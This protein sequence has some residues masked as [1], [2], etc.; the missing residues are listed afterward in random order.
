MY[1]FNFIQNFSF[2]KVVIVPSLKERIKKYQIIKNDNLFIE[3]QNSVL[4]KFYLENFATS[5][6]PKFFFK[7]LSIKEFFIVNGK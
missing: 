6:N 3:N 4:I 5:S 7:N 2:L 1:E